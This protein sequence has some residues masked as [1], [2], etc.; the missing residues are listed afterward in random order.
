MKNRLTAITSAIILFAAVLISLSCKDVPQNNTTSNTTANNTV[1]NVNQN[2]SVQNSESD[3]A[4]TLDCRETNPRRRQEVFDKI[5]ENIGNNTI[6]QYQ[7]EYGKFDFDVVDSGGDLVV[8]FWGRVYTKKEDKV[9]DLNKTFKKLVKNGCVSKVVFSEPANAKATA[10]P[11]FEYNLCESP[12]EVCSDGVCRN[13]CKKK[14]DD[15]NTNTN[16]NANRG[17]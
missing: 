1:A 2:N 6:L 15:G 8:Y 17:N 7:Y 9:D 16:T 11:G 14:E 5:E 12:N 10:L 4:L 13:G 3:S